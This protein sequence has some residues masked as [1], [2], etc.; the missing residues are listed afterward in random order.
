M[1]E[2]REKG[3]DCD[4]DISYKYLTFFLEDDAQ[5]DKIRKVSSVVM[6]TLPEQV[7]SQ[8]RLGKDDVNRSA[9][10]PLRLV[11]RIRQNLHVSVWQNMGVRFCL[12]WANQCLG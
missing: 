8:P 2:H 7:V 1:E 9:S 3:G 4:V 11:F 10:S 12:P 6:A 5:L